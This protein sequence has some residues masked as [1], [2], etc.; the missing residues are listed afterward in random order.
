MHSTPDAVGHASSD[1]GDWFSQH[2][3]RAHRLRPGR[4]GEFPGVEWPAS[5][6]APLVLVKQIAPGLRFRLAVR[7]AVPIEDRE[8][9]LA[10]MWEA[11]APPQVR[12]TCLKMAALM[13]RARGRR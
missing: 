10:G 9:R 13:L 8:E 5:A 12:E 3:D 1:D 7:A 2:R 4:K 11:L 6:T